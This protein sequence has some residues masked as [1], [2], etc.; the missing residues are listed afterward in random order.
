MQDYFIH[1]NIKIKR[2]A[3]SGPFLER[4]SMRFAEGFGVPPGLQ[5][6]RRN[7]ALDAS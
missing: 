7:A 6:L 5:S 2:G 4:Q 3:R 1:F